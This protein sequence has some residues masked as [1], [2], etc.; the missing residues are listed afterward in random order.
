MFES[1]QRKQSLMIKQFEDCKTKED[2][3][4]KII[5]IGSSRPKL[6]P[7]YKI[8]KNLVHGCQSIVYLH[9]RLDPKNQR[10]Y[11]SAESDALISNGLAAL[12]TD[13][14]SDEKAEVI[15]KYPPDHLAKLEIPAIVSPSRANGLASIFKK[16]QQDAIRLYH[17]ATK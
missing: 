17:E 14:Y 2:K 15:L 13:V 16:M 4:A 11:F 5:S 7:Q 9:S 8:E 3:Y 6:E 1:C 12:L 10:L